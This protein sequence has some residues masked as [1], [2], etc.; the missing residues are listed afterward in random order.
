MTSWSE[1]STPAELSMKSALTRPPRWANSMR[2]RCVRPRL[3]PSPT[4]RQRS[5]SAS[6]RIESDERS[7]ASASRLGRR[8]D[9]RADA[10]VP[11]Q[12][13]GGAQDRLDHLGRRQHLVGLDPERGARL[14][15]EL[16]ALGRPRVDAAALARSA[17]CRSR[18]T[19]S[20]R[21][22]NSRLRSS[23]E[24]AGLG[25]RVDE[26][27]PVVVGGDELERPAQQHAVAE[28]VARHVAD[29]DHRDDVGLGVDPELAEVALDRLPRA[30]RGDAQRLVVVARR[31]TRGERV[32]RARTC[33]APRSRWRCRENVAVPLSAA[34]TR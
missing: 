1:Q 33:A 12:V 22:S 25:V 5:W 19:T 9:H 14:L 21:S 26:D 34:T 16:D 4:T 15:G 10:A 8:L 32:A 2:A 28:H 13:D 7:S 11:Q 3:P 29:P 18:P 6:T 20:P 31:A 23:H 30:L 24:R 27:V 17:P